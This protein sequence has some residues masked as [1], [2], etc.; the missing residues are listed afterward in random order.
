V[1]GGACI[2]VYEVGMLRC[3]GIGGATAGGCSRAFDPMVCLCNNP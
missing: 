1:A 2:G 3:G